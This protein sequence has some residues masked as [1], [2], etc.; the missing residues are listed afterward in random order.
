MTRRLTPEDH[1]LWERVASTVKPRRSHRIPARD[2]PAP[3]TPHKPRDKPVRAGIVLKSAG[4]REPASRPI[5]APAPFAAPALDGKRAAHFRKGKLA[6]EARIDLHG[7]TLDLAH[8]EL[9]GFLDQARDRG[10]RVVLVITGKG[11]PEGGALKRLVP[12]WLATPPLAS[13]IAAAAQAQPQH[14]GSGALYVYLRRRR[15]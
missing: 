7:L 3:P 2:A 13:A 15:V 8:R 14:G 5:N 4:S 6:V 9:V 12:L 10:Q 1:D 11:G